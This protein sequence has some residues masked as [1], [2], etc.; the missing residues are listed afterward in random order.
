MNDYQLQLVPKM[1]RD[2]RSDLR[3][4]VFIHIPFPGYEIF[5]QLPWRR[6]IVAGLLGADLIGFQ[7]HGDAANFLRA[8]RQAAGM[9][10]N[11]SIVR[12]PAGGQGSVDET[13]AAN[14]D[15]PYYRRRRPPESAGT[16]RPPRCRSP[17]TRAGFAELVQ[18][19]RGAGAGQGDPAGTGRA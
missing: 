1:L 17:S 2:Q 10:T 6:Q 11:G 9:V 5:A 13:T 4:G 19:G 12:V 3:I 8:C 18:Q 14:T 15:G 7:R 16:C